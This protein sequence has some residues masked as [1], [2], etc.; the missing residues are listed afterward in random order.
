[1]GLLDRVRSLFGAPRADGETRRVEE[2]ALATEDIGAGPVSFRY[3]PDPHA[4]GAFEATEDACECCGE[5]RELRYTGSVYAVA[6]VE[7]LCPWCI[8]DG[9]AA[10]RFDASFV[11]WGASP[12]DASVGEISSEV[13]ARITTRTPGFSSVQEER[14]L[15]HC[16]DACEFHGAARTSDFLRI[17]DAEIERLEANSSMRREDVEERRVEAGSGDADED[18]FFKFVCRQCGEIRLLEDLD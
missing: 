16:G 11:S 17:S 7:N 8:A 12:E 9:S 6:N 13:Y 15:A 10:T 4:T 18:Y 2:P 5:T 3:H 1:M 14:W